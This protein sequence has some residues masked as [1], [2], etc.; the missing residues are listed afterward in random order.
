MILFDLSR[1]VSRAG[2][3]TP[4]GIDRVELAYAEHL[5]ASE[6][7]VCFTILTSLGRSGP[8]PR[9]AAEAY[10]QALA[11]VWRHPAASGEN[12]RVSGLARGVR[13]VALFRDERWLQD[14]RF[15][16]A[17]QPAYLLVS[18]HHL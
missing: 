5:I 2:R 6:R 15:R 11:Q 12:G 14:H 18:H 4:T 7:P 16:L 10:I 3:A 13:A 9:L 17:G 1:L 8:V